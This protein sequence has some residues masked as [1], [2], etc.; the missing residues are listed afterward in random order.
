MWVR[1][2]SDSWPTDLKR[3]T[4]AEVESGLSAISE[5]VEELRALQRLGHDDPCVAEVERRVAA[6]LHDLCNEATERPRPDWAPDGVLRLRPGRRDGN[7][8]R[9]FQEE[10]ARAIALV[11]G[12]AEGLEVER[13][14]LIKSIAL[15]AVLALGLHPRIGRATAD[16]FRDGHYRDAVL[17]AAVALVEVVKARS[18]YRDR[19]GADLMRYVFPRQN[20][21]LMSLVK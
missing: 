21:V 3:A 7:P 10:V 18:D 4:L 2:T 16:R 20:P 8:Q 13:A 14:A 5:R 12:L 15:D 1:R 6:M 9:A 17:N 19:D 11:S